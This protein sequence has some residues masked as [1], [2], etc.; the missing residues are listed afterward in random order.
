MFKFG[1]KG[2]KFYVILRGEV[3]VRVPDKKKEKERQENLH[4]RQSI[5]SNVSKM[6][7]TYQ[8]SVASNASRSSIRDVTS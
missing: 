3:S 7:P 4:K 2:D 8:H 1:D 6:H 5:V